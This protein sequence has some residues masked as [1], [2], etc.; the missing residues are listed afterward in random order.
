MLDRTGMP[1]IG[2]APFIV[3]PTI[4]GI[5]VRLFIPWQLFDL[6][7]VEVYGVGFF[8]PGRA[9]QAVGWN[10]ELFAGEPTPRIHYHVSDLTG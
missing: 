4:L 3:L 5:E 2:V 1:N 7:L 10:Q 6:S 9:V 8:V